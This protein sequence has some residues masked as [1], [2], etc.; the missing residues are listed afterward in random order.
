MY[1]NYIQK[2]VTSVSIVLFLLIFFI[3]QYIKPSFIYKKDG[4]FRRFGLGTKNKTVIPIWFITLII[5]ILSYV[6]ILYYVNIP[7]FDY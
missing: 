7:N 2:N 4:S 5:A 6:F 1:R 3:I